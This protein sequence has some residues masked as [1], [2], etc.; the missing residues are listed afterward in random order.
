MKVPINVW[1]EAG[2]VRLQVPAKTSTGQTTFLLAASEAR[3]LAAAIHVAAGGPPEQRVVTCVYCGHVY[4]QDTPTHGAGISVLTEHI[5]VCPDHP[6]REVEAQLAQA[7]EYA[8]RLE[9]DLSQVSFA[10]AD[11]LERSG[12]GRHK[13]Q[14][15]YIAEALE[16]LKDLLCEIQMKDFRSVM[17]LVRDSRDIHEA[18]ADRG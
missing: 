8:G 5:K 9:R 13:Y 10:A 6:M 11:Y 12:L 1:T 17:D 7:R 3:E 15:V 14:P 4:P 18:E 2:Y 16:T